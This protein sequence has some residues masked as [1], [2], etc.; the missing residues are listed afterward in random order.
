MRL[1][2]RT[3]E[4]DGAEL[5]EFYVADTGQSLAAVSR[6]IINQVSEI[7]GFDIIGEVIKAVITESKFKLPDL[8]D[9][10]ISFIRTML[11]CW[12]WN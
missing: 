1:S 10:E 5:Y 8:T 7:H 6:S 4:R 12:L 2:T 9:E 11:E 3:I